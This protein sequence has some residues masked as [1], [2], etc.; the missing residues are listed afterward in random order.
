LKEL[1]GLIVAITGSRRASELAH[2]IKNF[3]G[4]PYIAPTVGIASKELRQAG[5]EELVRHVMD[6]RVD[7]VVFMTG[8]GTFTI[9]GMAEKL[10]LKQDFIKALNRL[11]IVARSQKPKSAL[12]KHGV[13]VD[14]VPTDTHDNTAEGVAKE[15][16]KLDLLGK[17]IAILWHGRQDDSLK[18]WLEEDGAQVSM[19]QVYEYAL[20]L[21][22]SGA[23]ILGK[24]GFQ[25]TP[26]ELKRI[27]GLVRDAIDAKIDIIT[28]TSPPSARNLFVVATEHNLREKLVDAMNDKV[29][30]VAVGMPTRGAIEENGVRVDVMPD[31]YKMG[32]MVKAL[33]DYVKVNPNLKLGKT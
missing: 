7:Y 31:V 26:P 19:F 33:A 32:P 6:G 10:G 20:T 15:M 27:L 22:G 2:L 8:P 28:F 18:K 30:V 14:I 13:K 17:R 16:K 25:F 4:V 23:I 9:M 3:G 5:A 29:I 11:T 1:D 12:E 21:S 24:M